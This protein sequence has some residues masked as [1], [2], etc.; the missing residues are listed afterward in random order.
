MD[1]YLAKPV[2]QEQ[3]TA[4]LRG[5]VDGGTGQVLRAMGVSGPV[6]G[7]TG[8][9]N[10]GTDVWFVG[11]TPTLV[12]GFWFGHDT[13][14]SLGPAASGGREAGDRPASVPFVIRHVT[15]R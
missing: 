4:M 14:R 15:L 6:A 10:D 5:V 1:D 7:K 8:T 12:A 13:P 9:T 2:S 3:L 11:Y